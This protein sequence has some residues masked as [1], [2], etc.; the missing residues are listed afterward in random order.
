MVQTTIRVPV[1]L[2]QKLKEHA[3]DRGISVNALIMGFLWKAMEADDT[4]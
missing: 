3:R 4:Q 2:Y 1:K